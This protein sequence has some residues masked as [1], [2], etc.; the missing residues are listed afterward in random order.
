MSFEN[1]QPEDV[2]IENQNNKESTETTETEVDISSNAAAIQ[3]EY[4]NIEAQI[5]EYQNLANGITNENDREEIQRNINTAKELL[6]NDNWLTNDI[7]IQIK[8]ILSN[9]KNEYF[10]ILNI[11]QPNIETANQDAVNRAKYIRTIGQNQIEKED[12]KSLLW[13]AIYNNLI[14]TN[15]NIQTFR[16]KAEEILT[17][18]TTEEKVLIINEM[19]KD[20][21]AETL[22]MLSNILLWSDKTWMCTIWERPPL[23]LCCIKYQT[24]YILVYKWNSYYWDLPEN[25]ITTFVLWNIN[26][27]WI[28]FS[29]KTKRSEDSELETGDDDEL[30]RTDSTTSKT[31]FNINNPIIP[32]TFSYYMKAKISQK[33]IWENQIQS[34]KLWIWINLWYQ[35]NINDNLSIWIWGWVYRNISTQKYTSNN[36]LWRHEL[37]QKGIRETPR[38]YNLQWTINLGNSYVQAYTEY[39]NEDWLTIGWEFW[40]EWKNLWIT[41]WAER[42]REN[43]TT[44]YADITK[45]FNNFTVLVSF[46]KPFWI[47][48]LH[49][50][51]K[52]RI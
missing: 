13:E 38:E 36:E 16:E 47:E 24:W 39:N 29:T 30:I 35:H 41:T 31:N 12:Y 26:N 4:E 22:C 1:Y 42:N 17:N 33:W 46:N 3:A 10:N 18:K 11:I 44:L 37:K 2:K 40:Y 45:D 19:S 8:E 14:E 7:I 6:E 15:A 5:N 23:N 50:S 27:P 48:V 43:G 28:T 20:Q 32:V 34:N 51:R 21:N 25:A 49:K 52:F 9:V